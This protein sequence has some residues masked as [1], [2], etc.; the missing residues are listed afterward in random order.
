V[1][2]FYEPLNRPAEKDVPNYSNS[3][4]V[5]LDVMRGNDACFPREKVIGDLRTVC[6]FGRPKMEIKEVLVA[7]DRLSFE[8]GIRNSSG[9]FSEFPVLEKL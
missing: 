3:H 9:T 8:G 6:Y 7:G 2:P 4:F 1:T 5:G